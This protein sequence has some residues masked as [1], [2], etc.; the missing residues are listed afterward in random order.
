[1]ASRWAELLA[2]SK[3]VLPLAFGIV[4]FLAAWGVVALSV[5][6]PAW[7][8]QLMTLLIF[9][10]SQLVVVQLLAVGAPSGVIV[11]TSSLLNLRHT[12][13]SASL[14]PFLASLPLRWRCLLAYLLTDETFAVSSV[15]YR[16]HGQNPYRQWYLLGAGLTVW[17]AA[18]FGTALGLFLGARF[19]STWSLDF[20]P[21]L[22]LIA[23]VVPTLTER[24]SQVAALAA[25]TLAILLAA[26]P[27]NLGLLVATT[28]GV[29]SGLAASASS[30][31]R[32]ILDVLAYHCW[33]RAHHLCAA[34]L[35]YCRRREAYYTACAAT[36][37]APSAR[38]HP[39]RAGLSPTLQAPGQPVVW[40]RLPSAGR[41]ARRLGRLANQE[42]PLDDQR[43]H[44]KPV[45]AP[46]TGGLPLSE[47]P[48]SAREFSDRH[49]EHP[50]LSHPSRRKQNPASV[51]TRRA[52]EGRSNEQ[53]P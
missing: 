40:Q 42:R 7:V 34:G 52:V 16:Q 50:A 20:L 22:A 21:T 29:T 14:A 44:G 37:L 45:A 31:I 35:L 24:P 9:A 18:Q 23:L 2:G 41:A 43:R 32:R 15:H 51:N 30:A 36:R 48:R 8:A 53:T 3:A 38:R 1:M 12:L 28:V 6:I 10:G 46:G 47:S 25:G 17:S 27:L 19:P 5:G 13:Y 4:P 49:Q 33:H 39:L 26:L 11:A